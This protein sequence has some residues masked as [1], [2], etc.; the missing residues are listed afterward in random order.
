MTIKSGGDRLPLLGWTPLPLATPSQI[1][2]QRSSV[3]N[4]SVVENW[5]LKEH[6]YQ[7][8][9]EEH[10]MFLAGGFIHNLY[11]H[12]RANAQARVRQI[13]FPFQFGPSNFNI[14]FNHWNNI[15]KIGN[16]FKNDWCP[17]MCC[18]PKLYPSY[19]LSFTL[20]RNTTSL[21]SFRLEKRAH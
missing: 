1:P 20:K 16:S 17:N 11:L 3:K 21:D 2:S 14:H 9:H 10:T 6:E 15:F 12:S 8:N 5:D 7:W 13:C 18:K 4:S 19:P